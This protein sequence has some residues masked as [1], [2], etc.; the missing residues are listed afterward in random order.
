MD[1]CLWVCVETSY[2]VCVLQVCVCCRCVCT[3]VFFS[4]CVR[5][6]VWGGGGVR[7]KFYI[8]KCVLVC[9]FVYVCVC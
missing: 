3:S 7:E 1:A 9:L 4:A 5:V 2:F 6:R 8:C